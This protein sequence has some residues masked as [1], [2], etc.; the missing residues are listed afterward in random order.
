M[1]KYAAPSV[2]KAFSLLK[3]IA[4]SKEGL[5]I[6]E[7]SRD[8]CLAKSTVHGMACA[9]EEIGVLLRDPLTKRYRLGFTLFELGRL[10]YS[11]I[12]LK[13]TAR[14]ILEELMVKTQGTVFLGILNVDHVTVLDM[15][16]SLQ[17]LKITAPL[18]ASIPLFAGAV[19]KVFL[20][21]MS[22]EQALKIINKK[23]IPRFTDHTIVDPELYYQELRKTREKGYAVDDEEYMMGAWAVASPIK[24]LGSFISAIWVVDFKASLNEKRM[25]TMIE[26]THKA[27][28][29]ISCL[30]QDQITIK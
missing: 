8:L 27:A 20:S 12:D 9:L 11:Q 17:D 5:G 2:K 14:P 26:E 10:A 7:L 19:G 24:Q 3:T 25:K 4:A 16:E 23:G 21:S 22:A 13:T 6:S 15:V 29:I 1:K 18:G 30:T 28:D